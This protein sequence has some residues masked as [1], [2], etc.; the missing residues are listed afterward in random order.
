MKKALF[1]IISLLLM[2]GISALTFLLY[3]NND[4]MLE[5][6]EIVINDKQLV[7]G[8]QFSAQFKCELKGKILSKYDY[9]IE[10]D[11]VYLTLYANAAGK[12]DFV[13]DSDG[14]TKIIIVSDSEIKKVV[15]VCGDDEDNISF[16]KK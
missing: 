15:Y 14:Y 2:F 4:E 16:T 8:N 11:T 12:T 9:Y 10:D 5:F 7:S 6:D 1:I 13:L 3:V